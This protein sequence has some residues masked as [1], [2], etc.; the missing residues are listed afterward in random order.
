MLSSIKDKTTE[1]LTNWLKSERTGI[2]ND[3]LSD[4]NK[5][6]QEIRLCDVILVEGKSRVSDVIKT[7]T[8]SP[9][10]HATLYIGRLHDIESPEVRSRIQQH[11][12]CNSTDQLI[13]ESELGIGTVISPLNEYSD[14][15]LRICRPKSLTYSDSQKL[16][17]YATRSLGLEYDVRHIFDLARFLFP[18]SVLPR[19]WRSSLF[20][21]SGNK[22]AT[23]TVCSTLIAEAFAHIQFP[24]LP[25]V[26]RNQEDKVT[27]YRRNP[28]L[29]TPSDFD[30]SPY[31]EI[32]KYPFLDFQQ[33]S[34]Y[35]LLPWTKVSDDHTQP[36]GEYI[37]FNEHSAAGTD[38]KK[39]NSN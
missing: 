30:Y 8:Q 32:I 37:G 34:D 19:R 13:L 14:H 35:R 12:N 24:I 10:S 26:K 6:R 3:S 39:N 21:H 2:F 1:I 29:C 22:K 9:W 17:E 27:L 36:V 5:I 20:A 15:H 16:I 38:G 33:Y 31:F 7:V 28:R 18:W 23:K 25:L 4:F 11:F